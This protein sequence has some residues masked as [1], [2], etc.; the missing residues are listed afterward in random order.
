ML[1]E[2]RTSLTDSL[3]DLLP[4]VPTRSGSIVCLD[5]LLSGVARYMKNRHEFRQDKSDL[6]A[7]E[8][9]ATTRRVAVQ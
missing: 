1:F 3:A 4:L 8:K 2:Y 6:I 9:A 7:T 5:F